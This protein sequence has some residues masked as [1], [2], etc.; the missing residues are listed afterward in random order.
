MLKGQTVS[1]TLDTCT[2]AIKVIRECNKDVYGVG[3]TCQGE[4]SII[5]F[6]EGKFCAA[7]LLR[8]LPHIL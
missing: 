2:N 5:Y 4:C 7:D 8:Y 3:A 1:I 6:H